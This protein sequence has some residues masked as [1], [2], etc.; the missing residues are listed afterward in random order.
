M[1]SKRL[2]LIL[3]LLISSHFCQAQI[4]KNWHGEWRGVMHLYSK[5]I[6]TD[7]VPVV[8]TI[9]P[10]SDS[11][12]TWKTSY[13]SVK[14]PMV[15]DYTLKVIDFSKGHYVT[16]EGGGLLLDTYYFD[17]V[18]YSVFEV[19]GTLLTA[20]Y[21]L[22]GN[23]IIFEVT[24]GKLSGKVPGDVTNYSV[25]FLQKVKLYKLFN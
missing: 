22:L 13:L 21:R 20:I 8:L 6:L 9:N 1:Q 15:K 19:Q 18:L 11:I 4:L 5:G 12:L 25:N 7:S 10:I 2:I 16:D 17:D 23:Q 24:S 14:M 3:L